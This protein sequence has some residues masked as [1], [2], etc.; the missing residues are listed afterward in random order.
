MCLA[1][2]AVTDRSCLAMLADAGNVIAFYYHQSNASTPHD[3]VGIFVAAILIKFS[4]VHGHQ[5]L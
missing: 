5:K 1:N 3:I 2:Q 4:A